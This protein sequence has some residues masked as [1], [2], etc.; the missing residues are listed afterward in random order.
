VSRAEEMLARYLLG[1]IMA[2]IAADYGV[3][4]QRVGQ[5]LRDHPD[6]RPRPVVPKAGIGPLSTLG[7]LSGQGSARTLCRA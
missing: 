6:Y 4:R 3:T 7:R 2:P 5:L 1:E